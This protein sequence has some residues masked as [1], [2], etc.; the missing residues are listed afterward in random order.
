MSI[1]QL[2]EDLKAV[3][4]A[5]PSGPLTTAAEMAAY[6]KNNLLPFVEAV[7][8]ELEEMDG[9]I[10]DLV[11]QAQDVL[12]EENAEVFAGIITSGII[13]AKELEELAAKTGDSKRLQPLI[14]EW[15]ELASQGSEL[16][17]DITIP[18][19]DPDQADPPETTEAEGAKA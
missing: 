12:H 5:L 6:M 10:E 7:V 18:D 11:M 8:G 17:E 1:E 16:L 14:N 4:G 3:V 9:N 13:L 19:P 2:K 15:R